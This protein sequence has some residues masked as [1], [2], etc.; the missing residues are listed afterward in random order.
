MVVYDD[1][2]A[3]GVVA[4]LNAAVAGYAAGLPDTYGL[5]A[6]ELAALMTSWRSRALAQ[7]R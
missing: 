4:K 3:Q 5:S 6:D 2:T 7:V 1:R